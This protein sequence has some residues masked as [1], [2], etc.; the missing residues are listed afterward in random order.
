MPLAAPCNQNDKQN[1]Q[2]DDHRRDCAY[3]QPTFLLLLSLL[4]R[5]ERVAPLSIS[6][7]ELSQPLP[8]PIGLLR[9]H[10]RHGLRALAEAIVE[11]Q[12]FAGH[13]VAERVERV[14]ARHAAFGVG[15]IRRGT[16]G[17]DQGRFII[18]I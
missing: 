14:T 9:F 11:A 2:D 12:L 17:T 10:F 1:D 16:V 7:P 5:I 6:F 4:L 15:D 18:H 13:D 8:R 3:E